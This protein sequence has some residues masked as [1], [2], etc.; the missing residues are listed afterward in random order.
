MAHECVPPPQQEAEPSPSEPSAE[1]LAAL[2][3]RK[4]ERASCLPASDFGVGW[5][6]A[7]AH[8]LT[9][10]LLQVSRIGV[11]VD[12]DFHLHTHARCMYLWAHR[13]R[14]RLSHHRLH[15]QRDPGLWQRANS[16]ADVASATRRGRAEATAR[17]DGAG[18]P[19][20][21]N[22]WQNNGVDT[23]YNAVSTT[24]GVMSAAVI[25]PRGNIT[26]APMTW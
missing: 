18:T 23:L 2:Q 17:Q 19:R 11:P 20:L 12:I 24:A 10:R 26:D 21:G 8:E 22:H 9:Q 16:A 3:R 4:E 1:E 7:T 14:Y 25:D 6:S 15:V 13:S 5:S